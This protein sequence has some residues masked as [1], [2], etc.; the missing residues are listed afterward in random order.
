ML[1]PLMLLTAAILALPAASLAEVDRRAR[2]GESLTV[3]FFG[4]SLTW[5]AN[6]TD[7]QRFS[8]RGQI[9]ERFLAEYPKARFRFVDAA[10]GG[11]GSQLGVFRL[12]RDVLAFKP[13]LVFLDFSA[14]DDIGSPDVESLASYEAIMR[15]IVGERGIP[16]VQ[17]IFPFRWNVESAKLDA[18]PRRTA[19]L[20]LGEAYGCPVGDAIALGIE[21]VA[22]K[23]ATLDALWPDDG[24]HPGNA[25]YTLF[26]DAAWEAFRR[27]VAGGK[28]CVAPEKMLYAP[29]YMTSARVRL[30]TGT[31]PVGWKAGR[32]LLTSAFFDMLMSRWLDGLA[33]AKHEGEMPKA[34]TLRFR[35][36]MAQLFGEST[37][38]SGKYRALIDGKAVERKHD[39]KMTDI[40]DAGHLANLCK[41]TTHMVQMLATGLDP[42]VEHT[43]VIEPLLEKGQELRFE[44]LCVAGPG[45]A[46]V[47]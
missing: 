14:N 34:L 12:D 28:P 35:G 45:A 19:H 22:A 26:T 7:P 21:R 9:A 25:G 15:R 31:L 3:V 18:M 1:R 13:D 46:V 29:T 17:V 8:Y 33:I 6:A 43:L 36:S 4:A 20:A 16:L 39:K 40:L 44:S 42:A 38:T 24:V 41:G 37:T 11:T 23:Q 2:A 32:P 5:G 10:I 27:G 47:R 30:D